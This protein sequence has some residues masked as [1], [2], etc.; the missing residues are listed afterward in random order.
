MSY[1][2]PT[3]A[4]LWHPAAAFDL[5]APS[6]RPYFEER[7]WGAS[8]SSQ[9]YGLPEAVRAHA[10]VLPEGLLLH[11]DCGRCSERQEVVVDFRSL[12]SGDSDADLTVD[13]YAFGAER[14]RW[15]QLG[16]WE[17]DLRTWADAH[18]QCRWRR[19]PPVLEGRRAVAAVA[20]EL[21]ATAADELSMRGTTSPVV[22]LVPE[23]GPAVRF[24]ATG[25]R[26]WD[27]MLT[28]F[29]VREATRYWSRPPVAVMVLEEV[30]VRE[31]STLLRLALLTAAATWVG[32][33]VVDRFGRPYPGPGR[34]GS[35]AW[36]PVREAATWLDG[37]LARRLPFP[38]PRV[39]SPMEN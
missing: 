31:R 39:L 30:L 24:D 28:G 5:H 27:R 6:R 13:L 21:Q 37:L 23:D 9:V 3:D 8:L 17:Q 2:T 34:L 20:E 18:E 26:R 32:Y 35:L 19:G 10:R 1:Q 36:S 22:A 38:V 33:A 16:L 15:V 4:R 29:R 14:A 12:D 25:T 11:A 7:F